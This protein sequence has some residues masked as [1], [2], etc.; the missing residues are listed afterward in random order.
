VRRGPNKKRGRGGSHPNPKRK[1]LTDVEGSKEHGQREKRK[2]TS[3]SIGKNALT[4]DPKS[5]ARSVGR[6]ICKK[7]RKFSTP[8]SSK[9][10]GKGSRTFCVRWRRGRGRGREEKKREG[11]LG[12]G[13]G[14]RIS[15]VGS[16]RVYVCGEGASSG[17]GMQKKKT[18]VL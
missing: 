10:K 12:G 7:E 8:N 6:K 9:E 13:G 1:V 2:K 4:F 18:I 14:R 11:I 16:K 15:F 3:Y 17:A 5:G